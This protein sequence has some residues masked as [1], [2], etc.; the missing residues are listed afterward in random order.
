MSKESLVS[1]IVTFLNTED[2]LG[3]AVESVLAQ[4]HE[5]L[6]LLLVDDGSTDG[7][8]KIARRYAERSPEKVRY[9]EHE[10]HENRGAAASRNLGMGEARGEYIALLDSDDVWLEHKL[11]DQVTLLEANPEAGMVYGQ[12][13]Y[14][15]SWTTNPEDAH[16]DHVPKLGVPTDTLFEPAMLSKLVYPL[17]P[18]TAPCPSD[19]LLRRSVVERVGGF[20]EAFRGMYQLYDDQ[21]F[22]AKMYL[23]EPVYVADKCWDRYRQHPDQLVSVVRDAGQQHTVRLAF[24][25][26]LAEYFYTQGVD[27]AELWKLLQEK[28]LQTTNRIQT[29]HS[30]DD[31]RRIRA[32]DTRIAE[33]EG[34]LKDQRRR[35]RRLRKR[36]RSLTRQ[37]QDLNQELGDIKGSMFWRLSRGLGRIR[38]RL[39]R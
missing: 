13:Q 33:L 27:N 34:S 37:I 35:I 31:E 5:N 20:E 28:L 4:T 29:R 23:H 14:W 11:E 21:T 26:W 2:F 38:A 19:L 16:R 32:K 30:R 6:E 25:R 3:E 12:S 15:H 39:S 36:N 18:A 9:L 17:G 22:L 7:S 1:C 24:L 10:G 8:T